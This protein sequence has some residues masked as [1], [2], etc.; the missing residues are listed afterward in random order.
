MT[1]KVTL[2]FDT[3]LSHIPREIQRVLSAIWLHMNGKRTYEG[4]LKVTAGHVYYMW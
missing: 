3:F 2:L 4:L 1:L